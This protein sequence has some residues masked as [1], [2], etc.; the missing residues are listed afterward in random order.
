[1]LSMREGALKPTLHRPVTAK[2]RDDR[3]GRLDR[4]QRMFAPPQPGDFRP[5]FG[6]FVGKGKA[7]RR[8]P[9]TPSLYRIS[10]DSKSENIAKMHP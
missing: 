2:H 6:Q 1:M 7:G 4:G 5:D 3:E 8:H 10:I 9:D